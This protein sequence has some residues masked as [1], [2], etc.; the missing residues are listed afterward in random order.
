[1][2]IEV[3]DQ[4]CRFYARGNCRLR[5]RY[6]ERCLL[7]LSFHIRIDD[8]L[9]VVAQIYRLEFLELLPPLLHVAYVS[10]VAL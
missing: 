3:R 7:R 9:I 2:R 8:H 6:R 10:L 4:R 5:C 1:M